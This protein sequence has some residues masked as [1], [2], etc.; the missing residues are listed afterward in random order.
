LTIFLAVLR[1]LVGL[2][3]VVSGAAKLFQHQLF[4]AKFAGW[5]VPAPDV[6]VLA[7]GAL[8]IVCGGLFALG[9]LT[10]PVGML[11]A[12]IMVAA[13]Y[14]AG[15]AEPVPHLI[16]TPILFVLCVFFAWRSGRV[17]GRTPLRRPGVQ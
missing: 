8:E 12:T 3:F 7:V 4:A 11:L 17:P 13:A 6:S 15:R 5:G 2:V 10:R 9:A 1:T 14:F 16:V